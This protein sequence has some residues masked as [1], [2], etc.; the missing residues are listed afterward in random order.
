MLFLQTSRHNPEG[1]PLQN[2]KAK[3]V[4]MDFTA[5]MKG[6]LK[7]H[8]IKMFEA[9]HSHGD[10]STVGIYDVPS[11]E[12]LVKFSMEPECV[13]WM[14]YN[15]TEMKPVMMLEDAQKAFLK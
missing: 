3:K 6:L 2:E 12:A 1:C 9:W 15:V 13:T 5:K 4:T 10:H 7:K 14:A 11:M 8:G